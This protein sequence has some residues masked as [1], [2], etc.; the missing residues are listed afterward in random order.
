[1][2]GLLRRW[3]AT[4]LEGWRST[5]HPRQ[6]YTPTPPRPAA[7]QALATRLAGPRT[8]SSKTPANA[9]PGRTGLFNDSQLYRR[10]TVLLPC[11]KKMLLLGELA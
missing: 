8:L 10:R 5:T 3:L 1:M 6:G 11:L 7:L 4:K 2:A 9:S